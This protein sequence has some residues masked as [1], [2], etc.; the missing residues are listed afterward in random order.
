MADCTP[1]RNHDMASRRERCESRV[2]G[3][4]TRVVPGTGGPGSTVGGPRR[5]S[6]GRIGLVEAQSRVGVAALR[7]HSHGPQT[8]KEG[9]GCAKGER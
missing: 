9:V 1:L 6:Q 7:V 2:R 5:S 4:A 3:C 8:R